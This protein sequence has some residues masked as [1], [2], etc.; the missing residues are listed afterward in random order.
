MSIK[1]LALC[2]SQGRLFVLLRFAGQDVAALIEREG[3]Q[4]FAHATT[5]GSCVPSL[6]LPVDHGRVLALCP[7]VSDYE[8]ELA[9]LVL[10]FLDGSSMDVVFASGGQR[11]GS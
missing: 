5:S 3:S 1:R 4:A 8:H 7:S 6:V 11:L 10:P 9:V 2:R